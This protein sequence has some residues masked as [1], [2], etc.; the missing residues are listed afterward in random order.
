MPWR[1]IGTVPSA[2][3]T[4]YIT[5]HFVLQ[6]FGYS[7]ISVFTM[8]RS[9]SRIDNALHVWR[10]TEFRIFTVCHGRRKKAK[11]SLWSGLDAWIPLGAVMNKWIS[12]LGLPDCCL[13]DHY[14]YRYW[15][16]INTLYSNLTHWGRDKMDAIFQT[17]F[18]KGF[19][20]M[21][22]NEFRLKFQVVT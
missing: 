19:S 16:A 12:G 8:A 9:F 5:R 22:M 2:T 7:T 4:N 11:G 13:F 14:L 6:K 3:T 15:C 18:S 20:W 1:Q 10:P 17:T 21:K